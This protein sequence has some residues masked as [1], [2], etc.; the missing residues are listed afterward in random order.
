MAKNETSVKYTVKEIVGKIHEETKAQSLKLDAIN[1]QVQLTNGR[2][3]KLETISSKLERVSW[4]NWIRNHP[5]KFAI[6]M[7]SF[8]GVVISDFRQPIIEWIIKTIP[9]L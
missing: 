4:G 5:Y 2:V 8:F 3:T 7:T 1:T 6:M 9:F